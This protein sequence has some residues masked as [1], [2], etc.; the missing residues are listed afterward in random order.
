MADTKTAALQENEQIK[1]LLALLSKVEGNRDKEFNKLIKYVDTMEKQFDRVSAELMDVRGQLADM[2]KSPVRDALAGMV[3]AVENKVQTAREQLAGIKTAIVE[4][5]ARTLEQVKHAGLSGLNKM[6]SF[7][8]IKDGLNAMRG[9]LNG[10]IADARRTIA[11]VEAVGE[12]LR[13]VGGHVKNA[14]HA[15]TGKE[16]QDVD[17]SKEGRFQAGLLAPLRSV[18]DMMANMEKTAGAAVMQLERLEQAAE[19][20]PSVR[21]NLQAL[22]NAEK[23]D[24][25]APPKQKATPEAAL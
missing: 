18:R 8:G 15:A 2:Q 25:P 20:K 3:K 24:K 11:K 13:S 14:A 22:K 21:E 17:A 9:E 6:V 7:M 12:E 19:K 1:E 5:A 23:L 16:R 10:S 4:G